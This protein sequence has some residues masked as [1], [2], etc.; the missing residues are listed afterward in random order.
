[1][2]DSTNP[3]I[4]ANNIRDLE[5]KISAND[6]EGNPS[7]TGYNTLL[8]KM[9]IDGKKFKLS[10]QVTANPD[11]E[12]TDE[13]TKLEIGG[14]I[15]SLGGGGG[16]APN[17]SETEAEVGTFG[18]KTV[19][20]RL[21]PLTGSSIT[22]SDSVINS[23][24]T[25]EDV[26]TILEAKVFWNDSTTSPR[27]APILAYIDQRSNGDHK[28]HAQ[29]FTSYSLTSTTLKYAYIEYT[30]FTPAPAE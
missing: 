26:E 20:G 21:V 28:L 14:T 23:S 6:V 12:A 10:N 19:Y 17:Y 13:A 5:S 29:G 4:M 3:R 25:F 9:K 24:L 1:M 11:G 16:Y 2:V 8:T 30:K 15:Y 22:T 7:G 27:M 18:E